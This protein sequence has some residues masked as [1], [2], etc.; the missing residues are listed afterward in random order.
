MG[1]VVKMMDSPKWSS[2]QRI[3][4]ECRKLNQMCIQLY[5]AAQ[6]KEDERELARIFLGLKVATTELENAGRAVDMQLATAA[7]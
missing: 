6:E 1:G 2:R 5:F 7:V 4:E 3:A